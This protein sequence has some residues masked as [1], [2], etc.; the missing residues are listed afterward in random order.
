VVKIQFSE[1]VTGVDATSFTLTS[2]GQTVPA[3]VSQIS[4]G[5]WALFPHQILLSGNAT[6]T[7]RVAAPVC[8][9]DGN[10]TMTDTVWSFTTARDQAGATGDT[11]WP[12]GFG[13]GMGG[14]PAPYVMA[15]SPAD[16]AN[17]VARNTSVMATFSEPVMNVNTTTFTLNEAGGNGHSCDQ[18]GAAV[19]GSVTGNGTGDVWTFTPA[20][21]LGS[22]L[23]YCVSISSSVMDLGGQP[24]EAPFSSSFTTSK[25]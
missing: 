11:S 20:A 13:T 12:L 9:F 6:Y 14:D 7:A 1:P 18:L 8:D 25:N 15:I 24:M 5:T 23:L 4:D 19:S 17:N 16:G 2:G 10:C 3:F 21:T 22:R